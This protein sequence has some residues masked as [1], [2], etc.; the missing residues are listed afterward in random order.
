MAGISV[1][2]ARVIKYV[3]RG[4]RKEFFIYSNRNG[5]LLLCF[6]QKSN[7]IW[8]IFNT[9]FGCAENCWKKVNVDAYR[10]MEAIAMNHRIDE[11]EVMVV[12]VA[13]VRT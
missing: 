9:F 3:I 10:S 11:A 5:S 8:H 1:S 12:S 7:A 2:K 13:V 6:L 4:Y